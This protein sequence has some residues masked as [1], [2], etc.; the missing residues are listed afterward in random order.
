MAPVFQEPAFLLAD[1][2]AMIA[3]SL[4]DTPPAKLQRYKRLI[5]RPGFTK[6]QDMAIAVYNAI[7]VAADAVAEIDAFIG[8]LLR[9]IRYDNTV[10][11][12]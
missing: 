5:L 12:T 2:P 9:G 11:R 4:I 6:E 10:S 8:D 3:F 1:F 7:N